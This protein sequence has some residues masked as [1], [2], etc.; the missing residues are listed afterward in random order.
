VNWGKKE[1]LIK[2]QVFYPFDTVLPPKR[3]IFPVKQFIFPNL[4]KTNFQRKNGEKMI[5]P[6]GGW[7]KKNPPL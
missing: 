6:R 2:R 5:F 4:A 7:G 3:S 1:F